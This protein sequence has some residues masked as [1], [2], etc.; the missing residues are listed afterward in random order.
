ML[1]LSYFCSVLKEDSHLVDLLNVF[2][3]KLIGIMKNE[4]T[5]L[6]INWTYTYLDTFSLKEYYDYGL[7]KSIN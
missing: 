1:K 6:K 2:P 5:E 3:M 4:P 7:I